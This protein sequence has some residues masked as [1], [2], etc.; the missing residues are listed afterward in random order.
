MYLLRA[1]YSGVPIATLV[2]AV[3]NWKLSGVYLEKNDKQTVVFI[4]CN[5]I[6]FKNK[7]N[8]RITGSCNMNKSQKQQMRHRSIFCRIP[9]ILSS[10]IG[11]INF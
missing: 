2:I 10:R 1:I 6:L 4:P 9:L 3:E 7:K 11:K 5:G 8:Q